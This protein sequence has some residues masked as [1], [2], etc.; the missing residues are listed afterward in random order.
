VLSGAGLRDLVL[1]ERKYPQR[2]SPGDFYGWHVWGGR[3]RYLRWI[4]D[5]DT[6]QRLERDAVGALERRFTDGIRSVST[7]RLAVGTKPA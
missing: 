3:G 6:W 1:E 2:L 4:S 7:A 5:D